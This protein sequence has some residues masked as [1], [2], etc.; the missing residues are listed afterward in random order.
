MPDG[1]PDNPQAIMGPAPAAD[2]F[3]VTREQN[4]PVPGDWVPLRGKYVKIVSVGKGHDAAKD[5]GPGKLEFAKFVLDRNYGE[6]AGNPQQL[7]GIV[8]I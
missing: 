2:L 7:S 6:L 8:L 3:Q 5:P 4:P 1:V